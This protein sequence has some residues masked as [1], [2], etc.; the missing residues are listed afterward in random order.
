MNA[1]EKWTSSA[2]PR[3]TK[4]VSKALSAVVWAG[5]SHAELVG[6]TSAPSRH[7]LTNICGDCRPEVLAALAKL[8]EDFGGEITRDNCRKIIERAGLLQRQAQESMPVEDLTTTP[9]HDAEREAEH[10][11]LDVQRQAKADQH[12]AEVRDTSAELQARYPWAVPASDKLSEHAR[13][14]KNLKIELARAFPGIRFRVRSSSFSMGDSVD[15]GWELGPTSAEVEAITGKYQYGHFD[16]MEDIYRH[17]HSA[18][19]AAVAR[20]LGQS[21]YVMAQRGHPDDLCEQI[22]R[23][24]CDLQHVEH[25]GIFTR[26]LCGPADCHDLGTHVYRLLGRTSFAPGEHYAGVRYTTDAEREANHAVVD[27]WA[28]IIKA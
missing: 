28:T 10:K 15:V 16:G 22:G 1:S 11:R 23:D 20:I 18:D 5:K 12:A 4:D 26:G 21:K 13:A 19:S 2:G 6:A 24:L 17:D 7:V 25:A 27:D 3:Q 14:S 8:R 9:E